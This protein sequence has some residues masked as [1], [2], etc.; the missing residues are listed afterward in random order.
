MKKIKFLFI[1]V[2]ALSLAA[3]SGPAENAA[4]GATTDST[5]VSVDTVST[6]ADSS[7]VD[8]PAAH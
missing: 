5:A 1:A 4:E 2:I 8:S 7:V 6:A 3:C